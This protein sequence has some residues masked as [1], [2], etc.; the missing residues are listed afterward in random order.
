M[1]VALHHDPGSLRSTNL[2]TSMAD[3]VRR[4]G[5]EAILVANFQPLDD[6]DIGFA[7]G[8]GHP[9]MFDAYQKRGGTFVYADLGWW[10]RKPALRPNDGYHKLVVG[11]RDPVAYFRG[12]HDDSRMN[13]L[14]IKIAPWRTEGRTIVLAGMSAKSAKTRGFAPY[15]WERAAIERIRQHTDRPIVFRPKPSWAEAKPIDG[16]RFSP[17]GQVLAEALQKCWAVVTLHSNVAVDALCAGIPCVAEEGVA[18]CLSGTYEALDAP[19]LP[20]GREQL[21]ADIAWQQWSTD[22]MRVGLAWRHLKEAGLL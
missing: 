6:A 1:R 4:G 20:D 15:E 2:A 7:Y 17:P 12:K 18:A 21:V 14:G 16:C 8:W 19:E 3:G 10:D 9:K 22:E 5:D 11:A 13:A